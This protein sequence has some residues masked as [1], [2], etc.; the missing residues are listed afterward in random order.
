MKGKI[1]PTEYSKDIER[2]RRAEC[3]SH[4][5]PGMDSLGQACPSGLVPD[6]SQAPVPRLQPS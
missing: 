4:D 1:S 3:K 2:I 5:E 6:R